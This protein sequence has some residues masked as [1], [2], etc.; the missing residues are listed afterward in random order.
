MIT[1]E[2][3]SIAIKYEKAY[4]LENF[5]LTVS[6]GEILVLLGESGCG[7]STLLKMIAGILRPEIGQILLD[8]IIINN[9]SP[10]SREIG[11]VPQAQVLFPHLTVRQNIEFGMK[12]QKYSRTLM[13]EKLEDIVNLTQL[14]DLLD[15][16]PSELSGGQQQRVAIA[17]TMVI[18]PK[19]LLMDEPL[20]SI[21]S[22]AREKLALMI[23][24]INKTL[25]T[26]VL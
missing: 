10:Q 17:R 2:I 18:N 15:R 7:K 13:K 21:D 9:L 11:Y 16:Y 12:A 25:N 3:K 6:K 23:R 8:S 5:S 4:I 22:F 14:S 20:S 1:L 24:Q 19:I 26:T